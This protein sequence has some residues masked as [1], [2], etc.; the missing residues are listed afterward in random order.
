MVNTSKPNNLYTY[1]KSKT[2]CLLFILVFLLQACNG[3]AKK[4]DSNTNE[5]ATQRGIATKSNKKNN[6][7][8]LD[9]VLVKD[10]NY[11]TQADGN[12]RVYVAE[13]LFTG[14]AISR[15]TNGAVFTEKN[16]QEGIE[17]G[18]WIVWQKTGKPMKSGSMKNGKRHG[19]HYEYYKSGKKKYEQ[20]YVNN[21]KEGKWYSWYENG[22]KWTE[23]DFEQDVLN[24][25]V[26]VW[27][28]LGTLTKEY[29]YSNGNMIDKQFYFEEKK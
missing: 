22:G 11:K 9:T 5:N 28:S 14:V 26:L 17:E 20:P 1:Y 12:K 8:A 27:D 4:V 13:K 24:G 16:Y 2:L 25:K 19:K 7:L 29:T 3:D 18:A 10:L 23:R 21:K 6:A 15:H